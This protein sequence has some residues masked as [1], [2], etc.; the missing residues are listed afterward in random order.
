MKSGYFI[1]RLW[2]TGNVGS[3]NIERLDGQHK[4]GYST[5]NQA[6]HAMIDMREEGNWELNHKGFN[7]TIM[8]LFFN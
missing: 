5:Y 2:Q 3:H 7:F 1:M 6:K 8:E 4:N